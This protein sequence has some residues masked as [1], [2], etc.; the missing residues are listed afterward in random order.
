MRLLFACVMVLSEMA[1][2]ASVDHVELVFPYPWIATEGLEMP[3][4]GIRGPDNA[5]PRLQNFVRQVDVIE[6]V[7]KGERHASEGH[8]V[9]PAYGHTGTRDPTHLPGNDSVTERPYRTN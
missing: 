5:F 2:P 3:Q 7:W 6:A 9:L 1:T 8:V 4:L